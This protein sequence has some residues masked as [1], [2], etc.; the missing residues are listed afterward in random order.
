MN[1]SN[2]SIMQGRLIEPEIDKIQSFPF[3]NWE[4]EFQILK[5]LKIKKLQWIY[6]N[7]NNMIN[8]LRKKILLIKNYFLKKNIKF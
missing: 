6:E 3:K 8:P 4:K 1:I 2:I 5:D 7:S